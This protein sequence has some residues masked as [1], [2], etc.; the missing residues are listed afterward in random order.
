MAIFKASDKTR[1]R[2]WR[3][4]YADLAESRPSAFLAFSPAPS[5]AKAPSAAS[6]FCYDSPH[7][8]GSVL[9]L[10]TLGQI[11]SLRKTRN[12]DFRP[13][14]LRCWCD[15]PVWQSVSV[16]APDVVDCLNR[17]CPSLNRRAG[18]CH[19]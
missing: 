11:G 16:T 15:Q 6:S 14:P 17:R 9:T 13:A 12:S 5:S 1:N 8:S 3:F 19:H 7:Q 18:R 10:P 2:A 4:V